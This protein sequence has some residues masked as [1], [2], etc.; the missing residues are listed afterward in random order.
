MFAALLL[1]GTAAHAQDAPPPAAVAEPED[2][3]P[4]LRIIGFGDANFF[5]T[6]DDTV[7]PASGFFEGQFIL[8]FT[9]ELGERLTFFAETSL[10]AR[11]DAATTAAA[12]GFAA[13]LERAVLKYSRS[14]ALKLSIGRYHTP[15]NYWN[16]AFHHGQWLQTSV[17]R[18]EM[19]QFGGRF[20]PVHFVGVLGEGT[21]GVGH[22]TLEYTAGIGNGRASV[23]SRGGDAG[24][25]NDGR[26]AL[27]GVSVRPDRPFGAQAGLAVY[28][29]LVTVAATGG[30]AQEHREW[31]LA[32]H[33]ALTKE[34][35]ELLAEFA[36]VWHTDLRTGE[37]R[38][39]EAAY[40]Q[41]AYRLPA[42]GRK[43][44]PYARWE[45]IRVADADTVYA[46]LDDRDS[47]LA[48][49]R[50]DAAALAAIKAEYRR[51]RTADRP[52]VYSVFLQVSFTF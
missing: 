24:D 27:A 4:R 43:F 35:P 41:A 16:I 29:D 12:H 9:S 11:R 25:V 39:S 45:R 31:I 7:E 20:L 23:V 8:H 22:F 52:Y 42:L 3:Y 38:R 1:A 47:F 34:T 37:R 48:G 2:A 5:A 28:R 18:P 30:P 26:A 51:Q 10:T 14:D 33:L 44:K 15:I 13:E 32:G 40:V 19:I 21:A 49:T 17:N 46:T 6:D 36:Q 50:Y